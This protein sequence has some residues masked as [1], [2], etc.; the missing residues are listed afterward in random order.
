MDMISQRRFLEQEKAHKNSIWTSSLSGGSRLALL[1]TV[2]AS[3]SLPTLTSQRGEKGIKKIPP[4]STK[5]G[6]NCNASGI[7]HAAG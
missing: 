2:K 4:P 1:K 5:A 6:T 7:R 3:S